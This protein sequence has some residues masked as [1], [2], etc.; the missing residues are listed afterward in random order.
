MVAVLLLGYNI[1]NYELIIWL[2]RLPYYRPTVVFVLLGTPLFFIKKFLRYT[3]IFQKN[4]CEV[5]DKAVLFRFVTPAP[6]LCVDTIHTHNKYYVNIR[7]N[8]QSL[9]NKPLQ[10]QK[11]AYF[12]YYC[13]VLYVNL[14]NGFRLQHAFFLE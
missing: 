6:L 7:V 5:S 11:I 1:I 10:V 3:P 12:V 9:I 14:C 2:Q 13:I 8:A 4:F